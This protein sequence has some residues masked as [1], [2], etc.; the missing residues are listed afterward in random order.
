MRVSPLMF[1]K[2]TDYW[3]TRQTRSNLSSLGHSSISIDKYNLIHCPQLTAPYLP[4]QQ[5]ISRVQPRA[6][7]SVSVCV[8][9]DLLL[10]YLKPCKSIINI[11]TG[12]F[13]DQ[14]IETKLN[15]AQLCESCE[16]HHFG[17]IRVLSP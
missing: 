1:N 14:L 13:S 8:C 17:S 3:P 9:V 6:C 7:V 11:S 16:N 5:I 15:P 10:Q 12:M 4:N 2:Q